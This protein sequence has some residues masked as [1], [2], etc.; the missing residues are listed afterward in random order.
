[1]IIA[2]EVMHTATPKQEKYNTDLMSQLNSTKQKMMEDVKKQR[3]EVKKKSE[4]ALNE[5]ESRLYG[6]H[7][8]GAQKV[9]YLRCTGV[10]L[11]LLVYVII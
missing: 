4:K 3:L 5:T 7:K 6:F 2:G 10:C 11:Y 1:M 8:T 9:P